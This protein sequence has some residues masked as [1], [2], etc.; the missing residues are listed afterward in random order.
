MKRVSYIPLALSRAGKVTNLCR[1]W[2]VMSPAHAAAGLLCVH[3]TLKIAATRT[4]TFFPLA[5]CP[6][7]TQRFDLLGVGV[8]GLKRFFTTTNPCRQRCDGVDVFFFSRVRGFVMRQLSAAISRCQCLTTHGLLC[9]LWKLSHS[10]R[11]PASLE[12][13]PG[14][15][16]GREESGRRSGTLG[17]TPSPAPRTESANED[18]AAL[19]RAEKRERRAAAVAC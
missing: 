3:R 1:L 8:C 14:K 11:G 19:V 17:A 9:G 12:V 10:S 15:T 6:W 4:R 5:S 18:T 7:R 13:A 2:M 16:G